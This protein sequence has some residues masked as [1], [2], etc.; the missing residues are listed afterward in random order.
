MT[1]TSIL[2]LLDSYP[3]P[4]PSWSIPYFDWCNWV[5]VVLPESW[6]NTCD[7]VQDCIDREFISSILDLDSSLSVDWWQLHVVDS[8]VNSVITVDWTASMLTIWWTAVDLS[9]L[10]NEFSITFN[11]WSNSFSATHLDTIQLVWLD[12]LRLLATAPN[13]IRVWLPTWAADMQVLTW[14]EENGVAYW[15]NNQCCAQ[16]LSFDTE[17]NI[18]SISWTN[19]V[20]LTSINTDNQELVLVGNILSIT[21]LWASPQSVDLTNI[22]EHTITLT[23]NTLSIIWSD[24]VVN[25]TVDLINVWPKT[26]DFDTATNEIQIKNDNGVVISD[27]DITWVNNQTLSVQTW[28]DSCADWWVKVWISLPDGS[29]QWVD[30]PKAPVQCCDDVYAC[31]QIQAMF[32]DISTLFVT[33]AALQTQITTLQNQMP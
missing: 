23:N 21:Q 3:T 15:N 2:D 9:D 10:L 30:I 1:I 16:T 11:D 29:T 5:T 24:W 28:A 14:D 22:N 27:V 32:N 12:W 13:Q 20:D 6:L 26:I 17:T 8:R 33:A 18:L 19:S 31:P 25:A 4:I 7:D